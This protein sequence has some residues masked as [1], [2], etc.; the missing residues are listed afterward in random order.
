MAAPKDWG[1]TRDQSIP[2]EILVSWA[3]GDLTAQVAKE[4]EECLL[5]EREERVRAAAFARAA[6]DTVGD[7]I[8]VW[9]AKRPGKRELHL[10]PVREGL[11]ASLVEAGSRGTRGGSSGR[12]SG[13]SASRVA[14]SLCIL[15]VAA[16]VI[17]WMVQKL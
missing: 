2:D 6:A 17:A 16:V 14:S 5:T 13:P 8:T 1:Y 12:R 11:V 7:E 3:D 9:S 4:V 10:L 15:A